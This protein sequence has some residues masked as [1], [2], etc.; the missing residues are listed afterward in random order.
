MRSIPD[1]TARRVGIFAACP[2][3]VAALI[4]GLIVAA[5]ATA[6]TASSIT[7]TL[8]YSGPTEVPAGSIVSI[9]VRATYD[10]PLVASAFSISAAGSA[11]AM[12]ISRSAAPLAANGL[13]YLSTT[14]QA[15]FES[16]LPHD[17][18]DS[19]LYEVLLDL[20]Y[21]GDPGGAFDGVPPGADTLIETIEIQIGGSGSVDVSLSD[22]QAAHT[23]GLPN[24]A[25]FT[26]VEIAAGAEAVSIN[27]QPSPLGDLNCDGSVNAADITPFVLALLDADA[28]ASQYPGCDRQNADVDENGTINGRDIASLVQQL[29]P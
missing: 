27:V 4:S 25:P 20:D 6:A 9:E 29:I 3:R 7:Y 10:T 22:V 23:T 21:D 26:S 15:P 24:G 1:K 11:D 5:G 8:V 12:V 14:S 28:F 16:N 2:H 17:L 13:S 19:E 18:G